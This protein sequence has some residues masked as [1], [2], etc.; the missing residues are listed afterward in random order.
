MLAQ[1]AEFH[2]HLK[3]FQGT[4]L[5]VKALLDAVARE[6]KKKEVREESEALALRALIL[7][8]PMP[9]SAAVA[10]LEASLAL[11]GEGGEMRGLKRAGESTGEGSEE[12]RK[13][14]RRGEE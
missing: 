14:A 12:R 3:A 5:L 7:P 2:E 11:F 8:H 1:N 9:S 13:Q 10:K 4:G 6:P